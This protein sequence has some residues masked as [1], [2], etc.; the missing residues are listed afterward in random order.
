M[1]KY[2]IKAMNI[3]E[4]KGLMKEIGQPEYRAKQIFKWIHRGVSSFDDM[5]DLSKAFR[6]EL[7]DKCVFY[8]P[9]LIKK[10][11]SKIDGTVKYLWKL[12]DGNLIESVIMR[13]HHGNTICVS[14][15]VG[16]R[17]SC[18]FCASA[19]DGFIR[20]LSA[21]E[22]LDQVLFAQN[23]DGE[24]ISNIVLMGMG[25]PLD[26]FD[27]VTRFL[28]LVRDPEGIQIGH[29]H[30]SIS[31]CGICDNIKRLAE[32]APQVTLSISLH[33]PTDDIRNRIMPVN[34]KYGTAKLIET[35]R[36]YFEKTHRRISFEYAMIK[37]IN[38]TDECARETKKLLRGLLCHV[39][40]IPLNHAPGKVFE[41]STSD[42]INRFSQ[43]L[44]DKNITVTVR[45]TL[46]PDIDASCG[47]LRRR[48]LGNEGENHEC[49]G[50]D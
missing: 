44:S 48:V 12:N 43:I 42:T 29:R 38:D 21:G 4:L 18:A 7:S 30:I 15:Q 40:L 26:N 37:D 39:N 31:T 3:A 23:E 32:V 25:E 10:S 34:R 41:P 2:D 47:Q 16:C 46:G 28:E 49:M 22:I 45:R 5:T 19:A 8:A 27:N 1:S 33:A 35:C 13:Y 14:T 36:E 24:R 17:M 11:V 6:D 9:Q 50:N 20:N